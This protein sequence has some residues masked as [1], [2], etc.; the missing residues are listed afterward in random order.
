MLWQS[1]ES[2]VETQFSGLQKYVCYNK[3]LLYQDSFPKYILLL[4]A[5]R[6]FLAGGGGGLWI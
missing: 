4:L 2:K 6:I 3:V 1:L 5:G